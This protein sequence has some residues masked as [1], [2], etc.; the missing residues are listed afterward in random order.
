MKH[1]AKRRPWELDEAGGYYCR[2]VA[3][4]TEEGLHSKAGRPLPGDD[5]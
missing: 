2:H 4:M 3:A 5:K 1:Y